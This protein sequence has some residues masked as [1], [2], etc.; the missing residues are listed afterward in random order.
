MTASE[1]TALWQ[2]LGE[3]GLV[4]GECPAL[5]ADPSPW[6]VRTMV[7]VAGWIAAAFLLGFLGLALTFI[8]QSGPAAIT[9]GI[10]LCGGAIA[11]LSMFPRQEFLAQ[12]ALAVSLAGQAL[13]VTGL[14]QMFPG[15]GAGV[16]VAIAGFE[17]ALALIA[18]HSVHRTWSAFAAALALFLALQTWH[19]AALFPSFGALAFV[20]L[21][22][23]E[24]RFVTL[25]GLWRA[26]SPGVGLALP[27]TVP[28]GVL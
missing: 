19:A 9:V 4:A 5:D 25:A 28:P 16:Y 13:V 22:A 8:A 26:T 2:E 18:R 12:F 11:M 23:A 10:L 6:Y 17:A 7:G 24:T 14:F 1:R 3:V 27:P 20:A 15:S 21:Q